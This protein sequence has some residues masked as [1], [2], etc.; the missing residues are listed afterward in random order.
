M[1]AKAMVPASDLEQKVIGKHAAYHP[2]CEQGMGIE[3]TDNRD[4]M[5]KFCL[6]HGLKLTNA[7]FEKP[8]EQRVTYRPTK[9]RPDAPITSRTHEQID[10][11]MIREED[12]ICIT[13]CATDTWTQTTNRPSR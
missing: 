13:D 8:I 3:T 10:Y 4:R 5:F 2:E 9:V 12:N 11:I 7:M 1:N 6:E